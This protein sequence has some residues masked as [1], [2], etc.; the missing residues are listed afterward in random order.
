MWCH[1]IFFRLVYC[2]HILVETRQESHERRVVLTVEFGFRQDGNLTSKLCL[3]RDVR[4]ATG[5]DFSYRETRDISPAASVV[6]YRGGCPV[7][8]RPRISAE[9]PFHSVHFFKNKTDI[10][11]IAS[12]V[13]SRVAIPSGVVPSSRTRSIFVVDMFGSLEMIQRNYAHLFPVETLSSEV[14]VRFNGF[15]LRSEM[16]IPDFLLR[17]P[18]GG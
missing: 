1:C 12:V 4:Y 7:L 11:S 9:R 8:S 5:R 16:A 10:P 14:F 13:Y 15:A 6:F 17:L 18:M 2:A 3:S